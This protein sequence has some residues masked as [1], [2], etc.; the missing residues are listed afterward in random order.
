MHSPRQR[1]RRGRPPTVEIER[2]SAANRAA[3]ERK[4]NKMLTETD[5]QIV[6][7]FQRRLTHI[8]PVLDLHVFGSRAISQ[9]GAF[10]E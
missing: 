10:E 9:N 5:R 3:L 2:V 1:A 7:E 6:R 4:A 8:V